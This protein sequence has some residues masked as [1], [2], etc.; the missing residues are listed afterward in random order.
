MFVVDSTLYCEFSSTIRSKASYSGT[1][2]SLPGSERGNATGQCVIKLIGI[3]INSWV[4]ISPNTI[5]LPNCRWY[6]TNCPYVEVTLSGKSVKYYDA[7]LGR[8]YFY[9][10]DNNA[11]T[12]QLY[13]YSSKL[14]ASDGFNITY[15]SK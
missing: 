8:K 5:T 11:L 12:I 3:P 7:E 9:Q 1:I 13:I 4:E 14:G 2:V 6:S 15:K 10:T